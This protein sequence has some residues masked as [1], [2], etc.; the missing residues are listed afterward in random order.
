MTWLPRNLRSVK[1]VSWCFPTDCSVPSCFFSADSLDV[2]LLH[3][4]SVNTIIPSVW[5]GFFWHWI[6]FNSSS[7]LLIITQREWT[8]PVWCIV[9]VALAAA[10]PC[11][12]IRRTKGLFPFPFHFLCDRRSVRVSRKCC[13]C[14]CRVPVDSTDHCRWLSCVC[15]APQ[16]P[17]QTEITSVGEGGTPHLLFIQLTLHRTSPNTRPIRSRHWAIRKSGSKD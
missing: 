12:D 7:A 10:L 17:Q 11:R 13:R 3:S 1:P 4:D 5:T 2:T 6:L 14:C 15:E 9:G 16:P 8:S